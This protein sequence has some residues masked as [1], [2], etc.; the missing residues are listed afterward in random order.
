MA[1]GRLEVARPRLVVTKAGLKEKAFEE[2]P[3][4]LTRL[5]ANTDLFVKRTEARLNQVQR[6]QSIRGKSD[7]SSGAHELEIPEGERP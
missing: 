3:L 4:R 2:D 6:S 7:T 5:V 1:P